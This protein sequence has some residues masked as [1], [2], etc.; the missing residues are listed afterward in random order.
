MSTVMLLS[1]SAEKAYFQV[2]LSN[3]AV[4]LSCCFRSRSLEVAGERENGRARGR[5]ARGESPSRAPVFSCANY[6]QAPATQANE[7]FTLKV[8]SRRFKLNRAYSISF[9]SWNVGN[10]FWS[11]ILK[12]CI[13]V[14]EK[15]KE[16]AVL[17]SHPLKK[18]NTMHFHVA[19]VHAQW[20]QR[21]VQRVAWDQAAHWG[22]KTKNAASQT[23]DFLPRL[24]LGSLKLP[25]N[26]RRFE[27]IWLRERTAGGTRLRWQATTTIKRVV[28]FQIHINNQIL[29]QNLN[30]T[31]SSCHFHYTVDLYQS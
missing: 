12:D 9:N 14:H 22:K 19:I 30:P 15:K 11:L 10:F 26:C 28:I 25:I 31:S 17:C 24:Q 21:N 7:N 16:V 8:N 6:F 23:V 2:Y 20:R 27:V 18:I 4:L 3:K 13:K 29:F 1:L 5:H